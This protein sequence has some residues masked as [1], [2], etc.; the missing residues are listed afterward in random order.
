LTT[1]GLGG[2]GSTGAPGGRTHSA[3]PLTGLT[4]ASLHSAE[5]VARSVSGMS[6]EDAMP[7]RPDSVTVKV[8]HAMVVILNV[9]TMNSHRPRMSARDSGN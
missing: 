6:L 9:F 7:E 8:Q 4:I 5:G 1:E 3:Y 2:G